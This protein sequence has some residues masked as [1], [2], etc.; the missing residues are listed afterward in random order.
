MPDLLE[1]GE[2]PRDGGG[3]LGWVL[4]LD[5]ADSG[6]PPILT[7]LAPERCFASLSFS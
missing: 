3:R 2:S 7:A 6:M 1:I 4:E 5:G